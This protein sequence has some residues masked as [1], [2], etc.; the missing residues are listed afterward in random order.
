M[1]KLHRL[2][3]RVNNIEA[4]FC[5]FGVTPFLC[6]CATS[7]FWEIVFVIVLCLDIQGEQFVN[8]CYYLIFDLL[9]IR[10]QLK[11]MGGYRRCSAVNCQNNCGQSRKKN[12]FFFRKIQNVVK[13]GW[14]LVAEQIWMEKI[15]K[16]V[17]KIFFCSIRQQGRQWWKSYC[18]TF[19]LYFQKVTI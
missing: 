12:L 8:V 6:A 3:H 14:L 15:T 2:K 17:L 16:T 18:F 4:K 9:S 13:N 5:R 19:H 7:P 11:N 1:V 10:L